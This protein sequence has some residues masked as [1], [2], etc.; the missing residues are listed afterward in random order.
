MVKVGINGFGRIG[1]LIL[2][3]LLE[4]YK[5]P[6]KYYFEPTFHLYLVL[7]NYRQRFPILHYRFHINIQHL[8]GIQK[9]VYLLFLLHYCK[10]DI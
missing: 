1:R 7:G 3:A 2:R 9:N 4:N 10:K 8:Q 6:R 5:G